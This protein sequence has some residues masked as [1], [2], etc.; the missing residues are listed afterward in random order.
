MNT[1]DVKAFF[2]RVASDWDTMRIAYYDERVIDRLGDFA[3]LTPDMVVADV[4]YCRAIATRRSSSGSSLW[5]AS[6]AASP[7][8]IS[9]QLIS[10]V[11]AFGVG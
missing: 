4:G 11:K 10:P 9:T 2:D 1:A 3:D 5:S 7:T 8:S 6:A